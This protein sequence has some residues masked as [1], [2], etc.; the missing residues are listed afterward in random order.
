MRLLK[1]G[2][3]QG[4]RPRLP[5]NPS[6]ADRE[7]LTRFALA[8]Q[9]PGGWSGAR[10]L[11]LR[12]SGYQEW[13]ATCGGWQEPPGFPQ[14]LPMTSGQTKSQCPRRTRFLQQ[15][16]QE[17]THQSP[18]SSPSQGSSCFLGPSTTS[19]DVTQQ[20]AVG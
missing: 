19:P 9:T 14:A 17:M 2:P 4:T 15:G 6:S 20:Q 7:E 1:R 5:R 12:G 16:H 13:G 3:R 18:S 8:S 10:R 11:E